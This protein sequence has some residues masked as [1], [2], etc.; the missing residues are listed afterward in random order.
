MSLERKDIR[1]KLDA[2][3]HRALTII[4]EADHMDINDWVE[5][6]IVLEVR[7]RVHEAQSIAAETESLGITGTQREFTGLGARR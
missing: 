1:A 6:L 3:M 5:Q 7:R 4:C 2:N